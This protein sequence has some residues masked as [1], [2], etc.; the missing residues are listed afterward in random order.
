MC[1]I[2]AEVVEKQL[3]GLTKMIYDEFTGISSQDGRLYIVEELDITCR[4]CGR[5]Q[6]MT[7]K[8]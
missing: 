2:R 8:F 6:K 1:Y 4:Y 3:P 7:D 5:L